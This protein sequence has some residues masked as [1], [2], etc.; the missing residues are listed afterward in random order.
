MTGED[1]KGWRC[2]QLPD[3]TKKLFAAVFWLAVWQVLAHMV[4]SRILIASPMETVR[5]LVRLI[6]EQSF[7]SSVL[8]S[9]LRIQAGFLLAVFVGS[10]L[11]AG[12]YFFSPLGVIFLPFFRL[13]K[14]IPIASCVILALLWIR[15][16]NLS[17]LIAFLFVIPIIY[18]NV[19]Q[20]LKETD[21][22]L[23]EM[24]QVYR[25]PFLRRLRYI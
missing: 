4:D 19:L 21:R 15:S 12:S 9:L 1:K 2:R 18:I 11:A 13:L 24:A 10:L 22:G 14:A 7:W 16:E 5:A 23:L 20:G 8:F 25:L 6:G 17:I 3:W